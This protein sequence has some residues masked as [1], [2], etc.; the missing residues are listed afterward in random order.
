[1]PNVAYPQIFADLDQN[2][3]H[4]RPAHNS[5]SAEQ[6]QAVTEKAAPSRRSMKRYPSPR[7]V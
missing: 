4:P 2:D 5:N 6:M 7:S 3:P 1:M